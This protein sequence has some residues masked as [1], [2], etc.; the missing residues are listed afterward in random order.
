MT[1]FQ[2]R[3]H[4]DTSFPLPNGQTNLFFFLVPEKEPM[5][6]QREMTFM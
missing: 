2:R 5:G 6:C 3:P 1:P 4:V